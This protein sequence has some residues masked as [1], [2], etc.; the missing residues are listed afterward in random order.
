[1]Y[2][3]KHFKILRYY[4]L[5]LCSYF[6]IQYVSYANLLQSVNKDNTR[7]LKTKI[8]LTYFTAVTTYPENNFKLFK[9]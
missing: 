7:S 1:M 5:C 8:F 3:K 4:F 6:P 9:M 2:L